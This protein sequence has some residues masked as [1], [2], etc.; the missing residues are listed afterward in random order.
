MYVHH[1]YMPGA[2]G[3]QKRASGHLELRVMDGCELPFRCWEPNL[4]ILQEQQV[5]STTETLTLTLI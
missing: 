3:G 5:L 4:G 2:P 1:I